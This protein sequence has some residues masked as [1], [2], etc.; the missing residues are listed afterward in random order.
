MK[1]FHLHNLYNNIE[2]TLPEKQASDSRI[3]NILTMCAVPFAVF[4][5][6]HLGKDFPEIAWSTAIPIAMFSPITILGNGLVLAS[7]LIDPFK[8]IRRSPV[9]SLIFSLAL[10]D[11]L[12]GLLAGPLMA[13]WLIYTGITNLEPF[14]SNIVALIMAV[15]MGVSLYSLVALSVDRR[16]GITTPLQ[17]ASRVTKKKMRY[18]NVFI[19]C[20][21]SIPGTIAKVFDSFSSILDI[22]SAAHTIIA[23]IVLVVLNIMVVRSMR[24]QALKIRRTFDPENAVV[25]QNAFNRDKVVTKTTV[26]MVVVFQICFWPFVIVS[27]F[28]TGMREVTDLHDIKVILCV[29]FICSVLLFANSLLNPFLY[30]LRLPKYQKTFKYFLIQL[31]KHFYISSAQH[32]TNK[33]PHLP[34]TEDMQNTQDSSNKHSLQHHEGT[35][36][37]SITK[38]RLASSDF[39]SKDFQ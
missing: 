14:P 11:L 28:V 20:Y 8:N 3:L 17:Y 9:S 36:G 7:I 19:W 37:P 31:R 39:G 30:A 2:T 13:Y 27:C 21:I 25:I 32:H 12:V 23:S 10:A 4:A 24:E 18:V 22:I 15:S 5:R 29:Y 26:V 38:Q 6:K 1:Y 16:I 34:T 33:L 35:I